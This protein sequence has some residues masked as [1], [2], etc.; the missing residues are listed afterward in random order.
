M[1]EAS[2]SDAGEHF[3]KLVWNL[4]LWTTIA[5][6]VGVA[7]MVV[8][9]AVS[10]MERPAGEILSTAVVVL[11]ASV[12]IAI[13]VV[14]T[15]TMAIGARQMAEVNTLITR[16]ASI[17]ELGAMNLLCSDKT[18][19]LTLNRLTVKD[20]IYCV[21]GSVFTPDDVIKYGCLAAKL[22]GDL[23]IK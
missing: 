10:P 1:K 13:E 17:E 6:L 7:A 16:L 20:P 5:S 18:G 19:T 15:V 23:Q 11:I 14:S 22:E 2:V 8:R 21:P 4:T 3:A 12:P 9:M